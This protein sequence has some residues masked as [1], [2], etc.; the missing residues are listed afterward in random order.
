MTTKTMGTGA[1]RDYASWDAFVAAYN[2]QTL[3][4]ASL[5]VLVYNDTPGTPVPSSGAVLTLTTTAAYSLTIQAAPGQGFADS[6]TPASKPLRYDSHQGAAIEG[7]IASGGVVMINSD[8][9]TVS[10]LQIR[11]SG[12]GTILGITA[13]S[14]GY[15]TPNLYFA[16]NLFSSPYINYSVSIGN[17]WS[18]FTNNVCI[19]EGG[20]GATNSFFVLFIPSY[21]NATTSVPPLVQDNIFAA[22]SGTSA[23]G[24]A[25]NTP[26]GCTVQ[27]NIFA[28]F[29]PEIF[30][31]G[32]TVGADGHNATD[33]SSLDTGLDAG[34]GLV[35]NVALTS[36]N[37]IAYNFTT[38]TGASGTLDL[39]PQSSAVYVGQGTASGTPTVDFLGRTRGSP[40]DIGPWAVHLGSGSTYDATKMFLV[41]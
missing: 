41:F 7:S 25:V 29:S 16:G 40:Y 1:G 28:G 17:G 9:V 8:F 12:N 39:R 20:G 11:N 24:L 30:V 15:G 4:A 3:S 6:G 18:S 35:A 32:G 23:W 38:P 34:T 19:Y 36:A 10:G 13:S 31:Q 33:Q 2:G 14:G 22:P 21:P 27:N 37:F 26:Y 5:V